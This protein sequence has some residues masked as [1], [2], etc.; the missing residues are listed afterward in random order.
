M[1][2]RGTYLAVAGAL[3]IGIG[4]FALRFPVFLDSY[5]QWGWQIRCGTG[6]G[7]DLT[8]ADHAGAAGACRSALAL[9]RAWTVPMVAVGA[10]TLV[11]VTLVAA[12]RSARE[13]PAGPPE[14]D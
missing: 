1:G 11:G 2:A 13:S 4:L 9:R 7:A 8:Q 5:D 14:P 6:Y 12:T 3:L 10:L